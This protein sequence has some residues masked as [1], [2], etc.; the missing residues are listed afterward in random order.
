MS[1]SDF[2]ETNEI[3]LFLA[4]VVEREKEREREIIVELPMSM[5]IF[6]RFFASRIHDNKIHLNF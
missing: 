4:T 6:I 3:R 2:Y 5:I 1:F